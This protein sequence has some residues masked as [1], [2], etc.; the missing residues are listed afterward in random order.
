MHRK[1]KKTDAGPDLV[2]ELVFDG[3]DA[4]YHT[5]AVRSF[6]FF[7][8]SHQEK[9][10]FHSMTSPFQSTSQLEMHLMATRR[11]LKQ[12]RLE[13][14]E[15]LMGFYRVNNYNPQTVHLPILNHLYYP[16]IWI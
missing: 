10:L 5:D 2:E 7:L 3:S 16:L 11:R 14:R 6:F 12:R 13:E 15:K 8:M 4:Q 9:E 1:K